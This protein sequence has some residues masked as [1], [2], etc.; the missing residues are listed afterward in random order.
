MVSEIMEIIKI[1]ILSWTI[2][3]GSI[4]ISFSNSDYLTH[5]KTI[6]KIMGY[7]EDII[8]ESQLKPESTDLKKIQVE[9]SEILST[10]QLLDPVKGVY[11]IP[12]EQAMK[13]L[14]EE[15]SKQ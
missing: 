3:L 13:L 4:V 9:E 11:R 12:I 6:L 8:Y 2:L 1:L 15:A 10:Y 5:P 14:A 7:K